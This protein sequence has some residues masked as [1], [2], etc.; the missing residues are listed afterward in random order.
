MKSIFI[1][2]RVMTTKWYFRFM[3]ALVG[4]NQGYNCFFRVLKMKKAVI[5]TAHNILNQE[6]KT[7]VPKKKTSVSAPPARLELATNWLTA[8]CS[9][10]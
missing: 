2:E 3:R 5:Q 8:N 4:Q 10:D 1:S 9:T 6:K 7:D